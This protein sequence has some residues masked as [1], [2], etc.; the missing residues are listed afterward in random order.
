LCGAEGVSGIA[1]REGGRPRL[2]PPRPILA[3][4]DTLP[5]PDRSGPARLL[6][7]VPTA[8][9]M[10]SRGCV[11]RCDYCCITTLHRLAPGRR[12][13]QRAPESV[14][15]EMAGLYHHQGVRQFVFHDDNFLVPNYA[16]NVR[17]IEALEGALRRH[18]V[19]DIALVLKCSPRD[20]DRRILARLKELGLIRIF[21]GIESGTQC[22]LDAIGR[23]Q[24]VA[25]A[26]GALGLCEELDIS[27]QYTLITFQPEASPESMLADLDFVGRHPAHPLNYCRAEL[28]A[29]TP[30]E[31]RM[32]DGGRTEGDYLGR[33][34]R[35]TDPRVEQIWDMGKDLF[36][37]RCWGQDEIL[38]Q[39][40]R[41]D[42]QLAVVRHFYEGADVS[43][44]ARSFRDW[45]VEL[46]LGT[47]A[48]FRELVSAC[49]TVSGGRDFARSGALEELAGRE[50]T[51]R[52]ELRRRLCDFRAAVEDCAHSALPPQVRPKRRQPSRLAPRHAAAVA[53][54]LGL[55][56]G[57]G[58]QAAD[59]QGAKTRKVDAGK[60]ADAGVATKPR[61]WHEEPGVAEAA[62]PPMDQR[63]R[64]DHGV[65][66]AAPPP[67][68][69]EQQR[70][71]VPPDDAGR[72]KPD[73]GQKKQPP[74][75]PEPA[76]PLPYREDHGAAE[77]APPPYDDDYRRL[78]EAPVPVPAPGWQD[79]RVSA[80]P[81]R[82]ITLM[83]VGE[84]KRRVPE[85]PLPRVLRFSVADA[86]GGAP[87]EVILSY[88]Q[89]TRPGGYT[90]TITAR[91]KPPLEVRL[92]GEPIGTTPQTTAPRPPGRAE[93]T[94]EDPKSKQR[95]SVDLELRQ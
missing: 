50:Q 74:P 81:Q 37:G 1:L 92:D 83:G 4:L 2:T 6:A 17:R 69:R 79:V 80:S 13:R 91:S 16:H 58:G 52:E 47:A 46:N 21:M 68:L 54:A 72:G 65:A 5:L 88:A 31:Q 61:R 78:L 34:Y 60:T 11:N 39:A 36:A 87:W 95:F 56:G 3:D 85:R 57:L 22:G 48:L 26:E 23:R 12:F 20:A 32:L 28:Y 41:L 44:L 29:G 90:V 84:V 42:H 66:E 51:S 15:Q 9:L 10:G 64:T 62:P 76:V 93:L 35:Y 63:Y 70:K 24:T 27:S 82:T 8:Y 55:A 25:E 73:A 33:T 7:G 30:L 18:R 38:G 59:A 86:S 40:I 19:K 43:Q 53:V 45:Q 14:A 75:E 71:R 77:A 67:W 94:F 49:V 89:L